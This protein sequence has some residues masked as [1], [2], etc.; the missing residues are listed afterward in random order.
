ASDP[1]LVRWFGV[2]ASPLAGAFLLGAAGALGLFV[3]SQVLQ[4]LANLASQPEWVQYAGYAGLTVLAAAVLY[5]AVKF[6]ILYAKLRRNQ[7]VNLQG[8]RELSNRTRLRWLASAK[9]AEAKGKLE[10][11]LRTFPLETPKDRNHLVAVGM[12]EETI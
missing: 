3:Y 2:F 6:A 9:A 7:Q 5:A 4:I 8:L 12:S 1:A 10:T 11:Y